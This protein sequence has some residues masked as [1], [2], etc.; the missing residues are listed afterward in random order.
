LGLTPEQRRALELLSFDLRA[1]QIRLASER[2]LLEIEA[3]RAAVE[4][5]SPAAMTVEQLRA[6]EAK[7]V[8]LKVASLRALERVWTILSPEQQARLRGQLEAFAPLEPARNAPGAVDLNSRIKAAL[9]Q[10]LKDTKTVEIE[11]A[12]G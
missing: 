8:E 4:A 6:I 2:E 1:E 9:D 3:Q 12:T 7:A 10:Q 5:G 11:T